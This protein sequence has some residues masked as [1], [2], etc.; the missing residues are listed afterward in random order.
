MK[1]G[2]LKRQNP[3][4]HGNLQQIHKSK[5]NKQQGKKRETLELNTQDNMQLNWK[6][7]YNIIYYGNKWRAGTLVSQFP[8]VSTLCSFCTVYP[9]LPVYLSSLV[10]VRRC[11]VLSI[12]A[13]PELRILLKIFIFFVV[14]VTTLSACQWETGTE[15]RK[16]RWYKL[17]VHKTKQ[18]ITITFSFCLVKLS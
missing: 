12:V 18:N 10:S 16:T 15:H 3:Q 13:T 11:Q 9:H 4:E 17:K 6:K 8:F 5:D 1:G 2:N 14:F 7:L